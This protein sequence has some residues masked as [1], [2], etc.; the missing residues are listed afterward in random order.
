MKAILFI[1]LI[2]RCAGGSAV[3]NWKENQAYTK[4]TFKASDGKIQGYDPQ[5][6]N[7]GI[8]GHN[9]KRVFISDQVWNCSYPS[10][11]N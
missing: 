2:L 9:P 1:L 3:D 6:L 4:H 5:H 10:R 11:S 8:F 7:V